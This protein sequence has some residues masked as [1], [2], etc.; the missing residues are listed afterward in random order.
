MAYQELRKHL[1]VKAGGKAIVQQDDGSRI[2]CTLYDMSLGGAYMIRS[3]EFGP[4]AALAMGEIVKVM[5]FDPS[6]GAYE[7]DAE[8]VR[9]EAL[10]GPGVAV[11][12]IHKEAQV[13]A[14]ENHIEW[15]AKE[16]AVPKSALGVPILQYPTSKLGAAERITK[17]VVPISVLGVVF[18][19]MMVGATWIK[20]LMNSG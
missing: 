14:F 8:V 1:R 5:M 13:A 4:P 10:D 9:L 7:L 11:R 6:Q 16:Q 18:G 17:A 3:T 19:L 12:W 20:T 2:R 15:E